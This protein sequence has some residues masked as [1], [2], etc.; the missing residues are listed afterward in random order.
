[1]GRR[2]EQ[3]LNYEGARRG[4]SRRGTGGPV[5]DSVDL[6][7]RSFEGDDVD[8]ADGALNGSHIARALRPHDLVEVTGEH[9]D[10][11]RTNLRRACDGTRDRGYGARPSHRPA[12]AA[13]VAWCSASRKPNHLSIAALRQHRKTTLQRTPSPR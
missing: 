10:D 4:L 13:A 8:F 12:T 2:G 9:P 1:M 7:D 5:A 11:T 6:L 3:G